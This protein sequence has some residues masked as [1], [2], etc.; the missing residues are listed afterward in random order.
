MQRGAPAYFLLD[1]VHVLVPHMAVV[2]LEVTLVEEQY[3][4]ASSLMSN[5]VGSQPAPEKLGYRCVSSLRLAYSVG[6]R[7]TRARVRTL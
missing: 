7:P 3:G 1:S 6:G 4:R 5:Q 2:H